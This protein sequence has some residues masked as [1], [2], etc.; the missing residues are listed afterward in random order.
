MNSASPITIDGVTYDRLSVN[1]AVTSSYNVTGERDMSI[2]LRVVPTAISP[3][4]VQ[5]LDS[6]AHAVFKGSL[7]SISNADEAACVQAM[8][9]ALAT[10]ISSQGW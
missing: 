8:T 3:D 10:Y 1:L 5:T 6:Q 2:A 7:A 9:A 4:G